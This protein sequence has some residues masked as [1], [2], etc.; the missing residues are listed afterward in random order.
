MK[1]KCHTKSFTVYIF[2]GSAPKKKNFQK[3]FSNMSLFLLYPA[4]QNSLL[5]EKKTPT[6]VLPVSFARKQS[7]VILLKYQ[8]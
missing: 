7:T 3:A 6:K 1:F 8:D 5:Q 2:S 4:N